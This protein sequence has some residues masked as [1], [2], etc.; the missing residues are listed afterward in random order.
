MQKAIKTIANF[1]DKSLTT[2]QIKKLQEH[3]HID[4]FRNNKS[5]NNQLNRDLGYYNKG[6]ESFVRNGKCGGW[7]DYF[8]NEQITEVED[9]LYK[10][11]SAIG[12]KF[13]I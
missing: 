1:L 9:W 13:K 3:L 4:S 11:E 5:V 2:E 12:I 6:T 10:H 8:N 7:R